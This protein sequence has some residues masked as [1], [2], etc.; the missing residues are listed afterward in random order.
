[1]QELVDIRKRRE[2]AARWYAQHREATLARRGK[3]TGADDLTDETV[4]RLVHE[5]R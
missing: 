4:D 2:D 3:E 5:L 1:M